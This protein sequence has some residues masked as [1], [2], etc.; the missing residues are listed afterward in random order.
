VHPIWFIELKFMALPAPV[1]GGIASALIS[2]LIAILVF[3]LGYVHTTRPILVFVRRPDNFW[4]IFN[5]GKGAA[6]DVRF[7]DREGDK[8][9]RLR[10][11]PIADKETVALGPLDHGG[12]LTLYYATRSGRRRYETTCED[13]QHRI[14]KLGLLEKFP[15]WGTIPDET[16]LART[17]PEFDVLFQPSQPD[18]H[19]VATSFQRVSPFAR[20]SVHLGETVVVDSADVYYVRAR[21]QNIGEAGAQDVV[22]SVLAVRREEDGVFRDMLMATPWNLL[23]AHNQGHVLPR[24]P[25]SSQQHIDLGHVVDPAKRKLMSAEDRPQSDQSRTLFCIAFFVKSNSL[26]YLLDPGNYQID[27]QVFSSNRRASR[28]FTFH[29]G[30]SGQWFADEHRMF[31]EGLTLRVTHKDEA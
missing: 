14:R 13:W 3:V 28:I 4:R 31:Q 9:N 22:A 2:T 1:Q 30:I 19:R 7:E 17:P 11:Y 24:L 18:C 5:I 6:F 26:E 20:T 10:F 29:L 12:T 16:R 23:W 21:V 15:D 8:F 25:V 27:F